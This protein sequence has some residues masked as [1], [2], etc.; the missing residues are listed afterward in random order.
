VDDLYLSALARF[1]T[2]PEKKLM[3]DAFSLPGRD[4]QTAAEDVIWSLLNSR[5]F[6][7]NH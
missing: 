1:P 5:E 7:Y 4:R 2:P 3:L 6:I